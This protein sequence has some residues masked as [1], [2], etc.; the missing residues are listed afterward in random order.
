MSEEDMSNLFLNLELY[1]F[2]KEKK[3]IPLHISTYNSRNIF[4]TSNDISLTIFFNR[5]EPFV[6]F[7]N[8]NNILIYEII[9][10]EVLLWLKLKILITS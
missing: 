3:K 8:T 7:K 9:L 1:D 5:R 10:L 4:F 6:Y 2:C